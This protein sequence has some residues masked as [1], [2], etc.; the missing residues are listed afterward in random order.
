M[1]DGSNCCKCRNDLASDFDARYG[2]FF[3]SNCLKALL[4]RPQEV[5][6]C[7]SCL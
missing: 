2:H 5:Y 4:N 7:P 1:K 6:Y 3:H